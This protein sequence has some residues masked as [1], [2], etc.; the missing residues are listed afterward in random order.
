M[1]I[2]LPS[3][4]QDIFDSEKGDRGEGSATWNAANDIPSVADNIRNSIE[5]DDDYY[6]NDQNVAKIASA[7]SSVAKKAS[8]ISSAA[9]SAQTAGTLPSAATATISNLID[10]R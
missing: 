3:Y 5:D 2:D 6:A 1:A 10:Y 9:K 7:I 8:S 4:I